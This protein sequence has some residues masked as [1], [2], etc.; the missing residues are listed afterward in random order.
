MTTH[1]AIS[2][3]KPSTSVTGGKSHI[4]QS[5]RVSSLLTRQRLQL[6][7]LSS[8][9]A[10]E[11]EQEAER[12]ARVIVQDQPLTAGGSF[13]QSV[14]ISR[15]PLRKATTESAITNSA[16]Q[17]VVTQIQQ[18]KGGKVLE[19]PLRDYF[20]HR[21]QQDFSGVRVHTDSGAHDLCN[22][23]RAQAF[24]YG[25]SI[26]FGSGKYQPD[27]SQ[28]RLLLAH[29]LTHVVQQG[30]ANTLQRKIAPDT[31]SS[32]PQPDADLPLATDDNTTAQSDNSG[33]PDQLQTKQQQQA[34][35]SIET[36]GSQDTQAPVNDSEVTVELPP[37]QTSICLLYTSPS[38]RD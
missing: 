17:S 35:S 14:N 37:E 26:Y 28:G 10:D 2:K 24:T 3:I 25:N 32:E 1:V 23:I 11:Y 30:R 31:S 12:V 16:Q 7:P 19:K 21:F 9:P 22:R 20:E 6:K 15:L 29:E 38:P 34:L 13:R 36:E 27:H 4:A 8:P 18:K 5:S 33:E